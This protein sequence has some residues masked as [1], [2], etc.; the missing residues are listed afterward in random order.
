MLWC[1]RVSSRSSRLLPSRSR[2][3]SRGF[4]ALRAS[5]LRLRCLLT[6]LC[7]CLC[8]ESVTSL[9]TRRTTRLTEARAARY[10][11]ESTP[12]PIRTLVRHS[13]SMANISSRQ[14]TCVPSTSSTPSSM[15]ASECSKSRVVR[16]VVSMSSAWWSRTTRLLCSLSEVN[17]PPT[18]WLHSR[19]AC[20]PSSTVTSGVATMPLRL[21]SSTASTTARQQPLRRYIWVR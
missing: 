8:R 12:S 10:A 2:L 19:N 4:A 11:A 7:V 20:V 18:P 14:K 13:M 21:W 1:W 16:A 6:A 17:S 15:R 5:L 9:S 3:R